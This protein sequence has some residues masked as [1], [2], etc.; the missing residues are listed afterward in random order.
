[1]TVT[2]PHPNPEP[3]VERPDLEIVPKALFEAVKKRRLARTEARRAERA[4]KKAKEPEKDPMLKIASAAKRKL[5]SGVLTCCTCGSSYTFL[6]WNGQEKLT[7]SGRRMRWCHRGVLL[8]VDKTHEFLV[9]AFERDCTSTGALAVVAEERRIE[10]ELIIAE[11][12]GSKGDIER[13]LKRLEVDLDDVR[14]K[15]QRA[16]S[17]KARNYYSDR[18]AEIDAEM[19]DAEDKLHAAENED[20]LDPLRS[21]EILRVQELLQRLRDPQ[22]AL[23]EDI[24]DMWIVQKFRTVVSCVVHPND[25]DYGVRIRGEL[26]YSSF[27]QNMSVGGSRP[28]PKSRFLITVPPAINRHRRIHVSEIDMKIL[29]NHKDYPLG[30]RMWQDIQRF[31]KPGNGMATLR[32]HYQAFFASLRSGAGPTSIH[33]GREFV[34]HTNDITRG[35]RKHGLWPEFDKLLRAHGQLWVANL[36]PGHVTYLNGV[37]GDKTVAWSLTFEDD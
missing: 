21:D 27:F 1:M 31:I 32:K 5:L 33:V 13:S 7:C 37:G 35:I 16:K 14:K 28:T 19:K 11:I 12:Q 8:D 30:D 26:N 25:H 20:S 3:P 2:Y 34:A 6:T 23:S 9:D 10:F 18:E 36:D 17:E 22:V 29:K 24:D 15:G 4:E